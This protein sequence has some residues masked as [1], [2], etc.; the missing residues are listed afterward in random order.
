MVTDGFAVTLISRYHNAIYSV[1]LTCV[2]YLSFT[3]YMSHF[4]LCCVTMT[5]IRQIR[6][7]FADNS[8]SI[9][10]LSVERKP[11]LKKKAVCRFL[12]VL[13]DC[14]RTGAI[15]SSLALAGPSFLRLI[16]FNN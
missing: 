3:K 16:P 13:V 11:V 6:Q 1:S 9:D 8:P 4:D 15:V 2:S 10:R 12:F 14:G 7:Q 5:I